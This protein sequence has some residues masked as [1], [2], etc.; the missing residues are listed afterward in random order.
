[1]GNL[2]TM[3]CWPHGLEPGDRAYIQPDDFRALLASPHLKSLAHLALYLTDIDDG[4]MTAL[5]ES[6][7]LRQLRVLDLWNGLVGD[8]GARTLARCPDLRR[9]EK[10]RMSV[11]YMTNEGIEA[12]N[13]SG[14]NVEI[15]E[16]SPYDPAGEMR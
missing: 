4:C 11:R 16:P 14:A 7:L 6:G 8:E 13:A 5:V 3:S 12:L 9:L 1:L 2:V 15:V 10:V